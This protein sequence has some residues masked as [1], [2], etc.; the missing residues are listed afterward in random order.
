PPKDGHHVRGV[1][2]SVRLKADTT[3]VASGFSRTVTGD[4]AARELA[5][6]DLACASSDGRST[7]AVSVPVRLHPRELWRAARG[8]RAADARRASR[9]ARAGRPDARERRVDA[10]AGRP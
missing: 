4:H 10:G 5:A 7:V 6:L 2:S 1:R 9:A 8:A 3:Y